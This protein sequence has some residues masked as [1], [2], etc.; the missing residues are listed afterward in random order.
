[1]DDYAEPLINIEHLNRQILESFNNG[2]PDKAF[3]L[4]GLLQS[5]AW[6]LQNYAWKAMGGICTP[7][8]QE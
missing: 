1:M 3:A 2:E 5:E 7:H 6:K 4:I 8:T